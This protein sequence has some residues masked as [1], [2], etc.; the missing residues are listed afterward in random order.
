VSVYLDTRLPI[1]DIPSPTW[2]D[3]DKVVELRLSQV[4]Q[5]QDNGGCQD[6]DPTRAQALLDDA[7]G[8][9]YSVTGYRS[10]S[11]AYAA[12]TGGNRTCP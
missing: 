9:P 4:E 1:L 11:F 5:C 3:V 10:L 8:R 2:D 12:L 7:R 6:L